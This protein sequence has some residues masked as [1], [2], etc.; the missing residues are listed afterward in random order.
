[1]LSNRPLV[2]LVAAHLLAVI[3][4]YGAV[5]AVLVYAFEAGGARTT[6]FASVAILAPTLVGAPI[7]AVVTNELRP[8]VVRRR[9]LAVQ[10]AGYGLAAPPRRPGYRW[11][12]WWRRRWSPSAR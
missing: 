10:A 12:S 7:A 8:Q 11:C 6:G 4:E 1:M 5:V 9:G 3:A 2:R